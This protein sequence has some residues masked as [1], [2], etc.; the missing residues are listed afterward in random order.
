MRLDGELRDKMKPISM[1]RHAPA[2]ESCPRVSLK[3]VVHGELLPA[4]LS[5][6]PHEL[7]GDLL[8]IQF[9]IDTNDLQERHLH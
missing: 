9:D 6:K 8:N 3:C 5:D 1:H 2:Y 4:P 7:G